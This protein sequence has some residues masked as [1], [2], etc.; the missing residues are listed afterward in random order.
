MIKIIKTAKLKK[1]N[2]LKS[3]LI[4]WD[5]NKVKKPIINNNENKVLLI[6]KK[7]LLISKNEVKL[8]IFTKKFWKKNENK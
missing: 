4:F 1:I 2:I 6:I 7:E 8:P 5:V 3:K